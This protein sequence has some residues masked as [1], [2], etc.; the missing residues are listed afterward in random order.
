MIYWVPD[1]RGVLSWVL[2][3]RNMEQQ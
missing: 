1:L 2:V 3:S